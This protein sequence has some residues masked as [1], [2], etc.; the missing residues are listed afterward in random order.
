MV[1]CNSGIKSLNIHNKH[2]QVNFK[3]SREMV[4]RIGLVLVGFLYYYF[5]FAQLIGYVYLFFIMEERF[6]KHLIM[7]EFVDNNL[8]VTLGLNVYQFL[9][10]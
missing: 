3:R 8:L 10:Y 7:V 2:N 5:F 4:K 9:S 1:R 6:A